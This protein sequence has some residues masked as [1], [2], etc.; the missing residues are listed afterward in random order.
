MR[1]GRKDAEAAFA[2][3][4]AAT[5]NR[6]ATSWND[7]GGWS[8]DYAAC[9]GGYVVHEVCSEPFG[10]RRRPAREFCDA[11]WFAIRALEVSAS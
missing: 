6:I 5:G 8:L 11:V 4:A 1:Y 10:S 9:Y 2:R 7:V 3:L